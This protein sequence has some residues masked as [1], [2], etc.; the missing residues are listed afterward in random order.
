MTIDEWWPVL[1]LDSRKWL[2]TN[3]GDEVIADVAAAINA[4]GGCATPGTPLADEEI[5]WI[6]A[7]ANGEVS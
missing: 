1:G 2:V 7:T 6:E 5:D 3:N 4:A